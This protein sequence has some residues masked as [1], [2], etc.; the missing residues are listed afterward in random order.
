MNLKVKV[1]ISTHEH[2]HIHYPFH[3]NRGINNLKF[4]MKTKLSL[5][6]L[7]GF[8]LD[9]PLSDESSICICTSFDLFNS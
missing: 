1:K 8:D 9:V 6:Y 4:E 3:R 2:Y 5:A 7:N